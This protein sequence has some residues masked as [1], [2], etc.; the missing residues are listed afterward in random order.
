M[1]NE[2]VIQMGSWPGGMMR[3]LDEVF[4]ELA[5]STFRARFRLG[6]KEEAYLHERGMG[7]V[8]QHAADFVA[9]RLAPAAPPKDGK[10]RTW[11]TSPSR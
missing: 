6:P 1:S 7:V 9:K 5:K 4:P 11:P 2:S 8:L 3:S 10:H